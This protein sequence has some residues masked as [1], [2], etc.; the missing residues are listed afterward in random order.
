[1]PV[2][3]IQAKHR[4]AVRAVRA[5]RDFCLDAGLTAQ[6]AQVQRAIDEMRE[7]RHQNKELIK[8]PD[9]EHVPAS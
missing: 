1:M 8:D 2:F 7:W 9:H 4:L 5:Y 6:A 3:T